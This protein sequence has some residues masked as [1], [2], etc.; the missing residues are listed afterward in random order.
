VDRRVLGRALFAV[1]ALL[2]L[3]AVVVQVPLSAN[4]EGA[5]AVS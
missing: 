1:T 5:T 3:V 2:V 4:V